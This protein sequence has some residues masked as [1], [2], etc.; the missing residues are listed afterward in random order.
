MRELY[1]M[2]MTCD[3][4]YIE[5]PSAVLDSCKCY[6]PCQSVFS[7]NILGFW[8]VA[9]EWAVVE[10]NYQLIYHI[11]S[12]A[13]AVMFA[14]KNAKFCTDAST[15][16]SQIMLWGTL[17]PKAKWRQQNFGII[18]FRREEVVEGPG[19]KKVEEKVFRR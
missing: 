18:L 19:N 14:E 11:R 6:L 17:A 1:I 2:E 7:L 9:M 10:T 13:P 8:K 4:P 15:A 5:I 12:Q 16:M 3:S